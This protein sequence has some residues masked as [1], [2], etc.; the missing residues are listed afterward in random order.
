M[1]LKDYKVLDIQ[2]NSN[3]A[4]GGVPI[5]Q[6]KLCNHTIVSHVD[7]TTITQVILDK[8]RHYSEKY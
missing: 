8:S 4:C 5:F 7:F 3:D 1:D 6:C 2:V